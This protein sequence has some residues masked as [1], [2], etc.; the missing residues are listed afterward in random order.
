MNDAASWVQ[1]GAALL[2][3]LAAFAALLIARKAPR[4]AAEWGE[5]LRTES[6]K[7]AE[8]HKLKMTIFIAL[9]KCRAQI[10]HVD[11]IAALNLIDV[12]FVDSTDVR[13]AYRSFME[14]ANCDPSQPTT[15]IERYYVIIEKIAHELGLADRIT[16]F[17]VRAGYYPIALGRLDEAALAEA[18]EKIARKQH[19]AE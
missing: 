4:L 12:A 6:E 5:R 17:D 14:A 13:T 8:R 19:R 9:M 3:M 16:V 15:I 18:E 2:T 1:A 7:H 11:A 10:L